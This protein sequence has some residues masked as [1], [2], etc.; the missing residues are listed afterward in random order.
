MAIKRE[1]SRISVLLTHDEW[2]YLNNQSDWQC[3]T[4]SKYLQSLLRKD[5]AQNDK[6][7]DPKYLI[8]TIQILLKE[9]RAKSEELT[10]NEDWPEEIQL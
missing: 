10:V 8:D 1:N 3:T 4:M 5:M 6:F 9:L 2:E 7:D